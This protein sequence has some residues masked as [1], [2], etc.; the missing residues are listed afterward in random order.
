[1]KSIPANLSYLTHLS[2]EGD[3][4]RENSFLT[5]SVLTFISAWLWVGQV[6]AHRSMT[7]LQG[8]LLFALVG[9]TAWFVY[10]WYREHYFRATVVFLLTQIIFFAIMIYL[11]GDLELGYFFLF[12]VFTAGAL[13]G[14]AGAFG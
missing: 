9:C 11:L 8:L 10:K 14:P 13:V 3:D 6:V 2:P 5:I 7:P 4:F 12:S 1:M